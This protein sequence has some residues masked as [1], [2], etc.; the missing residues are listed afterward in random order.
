VLSD[1]KMLKSMTVP[2]SSL[3]LRRRPLIIIYYDFSNRA[4]SVSPRSVVA[5]DH[6]ERASMMLLVRR[7]QTQHRHRIYFNQ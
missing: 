2:P 5:V 7:I 1:A 4:S 3:Q 6:L